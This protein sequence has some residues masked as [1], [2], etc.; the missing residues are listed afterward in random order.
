MPR[1]GSALSDFTESTFAGN[2][3]RNF[4]KRRLGCRN[5]AGTDHDGLELRELRINRVRRRLGIPVRLILELLAG[6]AVVSRGAHRFQS[7]L[8]LGHRLVVTGFA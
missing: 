3:L 6:F 7:V 4:L 1:T 2:R 5:I 8:K